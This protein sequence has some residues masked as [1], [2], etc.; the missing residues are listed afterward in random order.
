MELASRTMPARRSM[1]TLGGRFSSSSSLTTRPPDAGVGH[2]V[3]PGELEVALAQV[4]GARTAA[5]VVSGTG[6]R[7]HHRSSATSREEAGASVRLEGQLPRSTPPSALASSAKACAGLRSVMGSPDVGL[8]ERVA[9][10][11]GVP[12]AEAESEPVAEAEGVG[13]E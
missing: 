4:R 6:A 8:A 7:P 5:H 11:E 3:E 2:G 13:E 1:A 10:A 9:G 12:E